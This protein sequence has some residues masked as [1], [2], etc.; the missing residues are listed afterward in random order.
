MFLTHALR[1]LTRSTFHRNRPQ[2][3]PGRRPLA[4]KPQIE[5]LEE[6]CL[7]S[8]T[9]T[10][11]GTL[12]GPFAS[13]AAINNRGQVV[14][15]TGG[16]TTGHAFLWQKGMM[17]DLGTLGSDSSIAL[18]INNRGQAVGGSG[19]PGGIQTHAFLYSH[20]VMTDLGTLG[21]D[22][23]LARGINN[24]DQVVGTSYTPGD[25]VFRAFLWQRGIMIDLGTLGGLFS[26]AFAISDRGQVVGDASTTAGDTVTHA[27]LWQEG[28]MTD[29]G[30][31]GGS[32]STARAIND[33]G[34]VV[35]DALTPGDTADHA[36]LWQHGTMTDLGTLGGSFSTAFA[37]NSSGAVVGNSTLPGDNSADPFIYSNGTMTDLMSL[38]PPGAAVTGLIPNGI[39]DRGQIVCDGS[40]SNG[41]NRAILLTPSD[42]NSAKRDNA[43][44]AIIAALGASQV[45]SHQTQIASLGQSQVLVVSPLS[46]A[47]DTTASPQETVNFRT[48]HN[49]GLHHF[50][51]SQRGAGA[52]AAWEAIDR[53]FAD[54]DN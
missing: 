19:T 30:T 8:Y 3:A 38:V 53:V 24:R 11:L 7:L 47:K 34:Q 36:F 10:D 15:S 25:A 6:R 45:D 9:V 1:S 48:L 52:A 27:F 43:A 16:D 21:G 22:L 23:S 44:G 40:D 51:A 18:G 46:P 29:L 54:F 42:D 2:R 31:L 41:D 37:I 17:T 32:F 35:G 5:S 33:R 28:T 49:D 4:R 14:G 20:G 50:V 13:P 12:G 26:E 39:N